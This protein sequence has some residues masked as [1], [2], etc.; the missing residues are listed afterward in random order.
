VLGRLDG[1]QDI[2]NIILVGGGAYLYMKAVKRRFPKHAILEVDQPMYDVRQRAGIP[3]ARRAVRARK[4][5]A[6]P[7]RGGRTHVRRHA[8]GCFAMSATQKDAPVRIK[9]TISREEHPAL[10]ETLLSITNPRRRMRRFRDL[11]IMGLTV[12]LNR[13]A[14]VPTAQATPG[15]PE[16]GVAGGEDAE[17]GQARL[18]V[19]SMLEWDAA[20]S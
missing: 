16:L 18:S 8:R 19:T 6:V 4:D 5:G 11:V 7:A 2:E 13:G 1:A 12:E 15:I 10:Y 14:M 3:V 20:H 9:V 17:A